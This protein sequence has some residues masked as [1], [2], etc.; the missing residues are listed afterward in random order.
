MRSDYFG[1]HLFQG[2]ENV[3]RFPHLFAELVQP[4]HYERDIAKMTSG[5]ML[6]VLRRVKAIGGQF[7][8]ARGVIVSSLR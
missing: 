6:G 8:K 2:L 7:R 1:A 4:G 5:K 3:S